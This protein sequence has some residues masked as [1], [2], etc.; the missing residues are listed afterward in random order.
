MDLGHGQKD[1]AWMIDG[2]MNEW[3]K[4]SGSLSDLGL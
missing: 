4:D 2:W 1:H 3:I